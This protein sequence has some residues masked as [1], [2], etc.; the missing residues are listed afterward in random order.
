M[1]L[2]FHNASAA[3]GKRGGRSCPESTF[4]QCAR[5][6]ALC[7]TFYRRLGTLILRSGLNVYM[8]K[9]FSNF[10]SASRQRELELNGRCTYANDENTGIGP[11]ERKSNPTDRLAPP[12]IFFPL[13]FL[14]LLFPPCERY[15]ALAVPQQR[16]RHHP[17]LP[18]LPRRQQ[19]GKNFFNRRS[20][21]S[22][23]E[24]S[25]KCRP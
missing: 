25:K 17:D 8:S 10:L 24:H 1:F 20:C 22:A 13:P 6:F 21:H 3:G 14:L 19:H 9:D 15:F 2:V 5:Q 4:P 23:V 16:N 11:W 12:S 7:P 18:L